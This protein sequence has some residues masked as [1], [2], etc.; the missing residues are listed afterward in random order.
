VGCSDSGRAHASALLVAVVQSWGEHRSL[1]EGRMPSLT[2][3][4]P[5][6][7]TPTRM[8]FEPLDQYLQRQKKL[9]ELEALGYDPYPRRFPSTHTIREI[10]D[11]FSQRA[12]VDFETE[13]VEV[14]LAGRIV[15]LRLHGKAGFAHLAGQGARL[16]VYLKLDSVSERGFE[17]FCRLDLG[18]IVGVSGHLFR[19]KTGELTVW[20]EE[21]TLL[22]KALLPLPGKWH[23]LADVERRYRQRYLDL[24]ANP[25]V[26]EIFERRSRIVR[27]MRRF[28]DA[29]GFLEVETPIMQAIVGGAM[30]RPFITYHNTLDLDLY[31]RIAPELYLKRLVVGGLDRVYEINRNFRNE[32]LSTKNNPEFTM[33]EFYQAYA[34]YHDLMELTI[35]LF[36]EVAR[37]VTGGSVVRFG[38]HEI[39]FGRWQR[40]TMREAICQFWP[41]EAG[42]APQPQQ[43]AS[44]GGPREAAR[45]YNAWAQAAGR[46]L[47]E[48]IE[49]LSDGELTGLLF[50]TLVEKQLIQPTLISDFPAELSPLAQRRRDD[51]SLA[52]RF[53][54]FIGGLELGNAY[55]ELNDPEEQE[56]RFREQI[57]RGGE[58]VPRQ[59]DLDYI[60][61]LC[62]GMPPAAGEG[63]GIDRLTMLLTD[64]HSIREVILFPLLR[65][66][67][68]EAEATPP[69]QEEEK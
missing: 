13:R 10:L 39:D 15:S 26:R 58:D 2:L 47:L 14:R 44:A 52:E 45:R 56:R 11:R 30:A 64:A 3:L 54:V 7:Y 51:P 40:L 27:E 61:A 24:I 29:R 38:P 9:K 42:A 16:Q 67:A 59:I 50:E 69:N 28:F 25:D 23:G 63:I 8:P 17:L 35:E 66:E 48:S 19:T 41:N 55:S 43:L 12:G 1:I 53:E 6:G 31:L 22:T 21:L 20:V 57:A 68:S 32:G 18:D 65:P 37:K 34:D 60:R 33:L 5:R 49:K 4:E 46:E 36:G 62:H